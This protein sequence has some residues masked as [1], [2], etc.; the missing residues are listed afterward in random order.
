MLAT[1]RYASGGTFTYMALDLG[2]YS[3]AASGAGFVQP[4]LAGYLDYVRSPVP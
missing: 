2:P 4:F 3:D 1:R